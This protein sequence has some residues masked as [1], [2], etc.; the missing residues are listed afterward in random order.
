MRKLI[1]THPT[2]GAL[3]EDEAGRTYHIGPDGTETEIE[4][5][6]D[7][8]TA[9]SDIAGPIYS[10]VEDDDAPN[11]NASWEAYQRY[12]AESRRRDAWA[13]ED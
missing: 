3:Y 13:N 12:Q 7:T 6:E 9:W 8:E 2:D 5:Q 11:Y 1:A 10:H 4:L